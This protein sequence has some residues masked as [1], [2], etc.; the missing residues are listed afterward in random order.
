MTLRTA[1]FSATR[2][3][4]ASAIL[5][6][7]VQLLQTAVLA[8]LLVP[9]DF[10]LMAMA[11][12]ALAVAALFLD[13]GLSSALMHFPLPDRHT[14]STLY[15]L[16]L[17]AA[18][19][20][21]LLFAACGWPLA[22]IYG[23]PELQLLLACLAL[24]FPL[25]ALGQQ[26]RALAEKALRFKPVAQNEM[27]SALAGLGVA[28]L[29]AWLGW[30]VYAI[31]AGQL[32]GAALNAALA[33]L[34]LS[35]G[36]QPQAAFYWPLARPYLGFGL[37]RM[38]DGFW[39]TALTQA[40]VFIA[41]QVAP[42]H[43]VAIYAVPREQNLKIAN[44]VINPVITRVGL[45]A[46]TR[47]K[48][49][50]STLRMVYLKTLRL[51]AS[52][53]FPLYA[54]LAL[55]PE[56]IVLLLLGSQWHEAAPFL[57]LFALWCLIRSVGNPSGSLLYAVGMAK[58]AHVWNLLLCLSSVPL[59]WLVAQQ[60]GL[61][62]LAQFMLIW[63]AI[64]IVLAWRFLIRPACGLGFTTYFANLLPPLACTALAAACAYALA[65]ALPPLWQ[66]PVGAVAFGITYLAASARLNREWLTTTL[67]VF[68]PLKKLLK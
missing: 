61:L 64:V 46:M 33:W 10:G 19:L 50:P 65:T 29:T 45:P 48:D 39:N 41:G 8:R 34:R 15:W 55:F 40:D 49:N 53:N 62:L 54:L 66:L 25:G 58:R 60:G 56:P 59:F 42:P 5:R 63:I 12:V 14:L 22:H 9:A 2:W 28:V 30:G 3:T 27:A 38:G 6:A 68:A 11:G 1:T 44:T 57:R 17:G 43:A 51:T 47:L 35:D 67:E 7:G 18:C 24:G 36:L 20:M 26:F 4:A 16:N 21:G 31:V 37:H 13:L 32:A 52:F 23:Q